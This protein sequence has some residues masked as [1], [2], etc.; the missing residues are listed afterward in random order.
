VQE[1]YRVK[2]IEYTPQNEHQLFALIK[3]E[4]EDWTYW[5]GNNWIKYQKALE[6]SVTYLL[7]KNEVHYYMRTDK[8]SISS[9]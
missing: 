2:I 1:H 4:G 8:C 3:R 5:Q 6:S 7:F 9:S